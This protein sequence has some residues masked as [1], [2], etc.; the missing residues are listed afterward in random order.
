MMAV[1]LLHQASW[2]WNVLAWLTGYL[3]LLIGVVAALLLTVT[4]RPGRGEPLQRSLFA[5]GP[6]AFAG[7]ALVLFLRLVE[8][9]EPAFGPGPQYWLLGWIPGHSR[10]YVHAYDTLVAL[11]VVTAAAT[12]VVAMMVAL[13]FP[14]RPRRNWTPPLPGR[15]AATVLLL[16]VAVF[17]PF[18][19]WRVYVAPDDAAHWLDL[20][21]VLPIF[22][23]AVALR[24]HAVLPRPP[25]PRPPPI[26]QAPDD[27]IPDVRQ[28]WIDAGL[29]GAKAQPLI[30]VQPA[31][32]SNAPSDRATRAWVAAEA[33]GRPPRALDELLERLPGTEAL[34]V[35]G[36]VPRDA[37]EALL[38]ALMV[39]LVGA[40]GLRLLVVHPRPEVMA[41]RL[42][43]AMVRARTWEPGA[44]AVGA[45]ALQECVVG[46]QL[47]AVLFTTTDDFALRVVRLARAEAMPWMRGLDLVVVH[48]PDLGSPIEVTHRAFAFRRWHLATQRWVTPP[49]L[50]TLP[51][52]PA[53]RAFAERLFPGREALPT[54]YGPRTVAAANAWPGTDPRPDSAI[55]WLTR[56]ATVVTELEL[57][58]VALDPS[59]RWSR[60]RV[61]TGAS[62]LREPVWTGHASVAEFTAGDVVESVGSLRNRLPEPAVH[63]TLWALPRDPVSRLLHPA[64]LAALTAE[65]R[66]PSPAP[67]VGT[68]N[69]FLRLAH[70]DLA[71]REAPTD[72][73][74]LR[75]AFGDDLVDFRLRTT[76]DPA[77]RADAHSAWREAGGVVRSPHL[78]ASST[79]ARPRPD[80]V[81]NDTAEVREARTGEVLL[82]VDARTAPTRFYPKRVFSVGSRQFVVPMHAFDGARRHVNVRVAS[83]R[84]HV[85]RPVTSFDLELRRVTVERVTRR[86]GG[87]T[88][89]TT[90]AECLVS[91]R[92]HAAWVPGRDQEE[93]YDTVESQYDTELRFVFPDRAHKGLGLFH[94]AAVVEALLPVFLRCGPDDVAV[95]PVRAGFLPGQGAGIAVVDRFIGGMGFAAA[96]D[97]AT[98]HDLLTWARV[99]LYECDCME[100]CERCSPPSVLRVGPAKQEVLGFLEGL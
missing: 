82:T 87:F 89:H 63:H 71:L 1:G 27:A 48:R 20:I 53:H 30:A 66:L 14:P 4:L 95:T 42:R 52:T 29:L 16:G 68:R 45:D 91:E 72:E 43:A 18:V 47:P 15:W 40:S 93:R 50:V 21:G 35:L 54:A 100:G 97:D 88:M 36:D 58:V 84:D 69:R 37:E 55:A 46:H 11:H 7:P 96:L 39:D 76:S 44:I 33:P 9:V 74:S 56:A 19:A 75:A 70:L 31:E 86:H 23:L 2:H 79:A 51:G 94:L 26:E 60:D 49:V 32:A 38:T 90:S 34:H 17:V 22:G 99:L 85:T 3:I 8:R 62:L 92:V 28:A 12:A 57:P 77:S 83:D 10:E 41:K 80:T 78:R 25:A 73:R 61:P 67:V 59:G 81:T 65:G 6:A 98:L 13:M 24:T 5:F 64:R